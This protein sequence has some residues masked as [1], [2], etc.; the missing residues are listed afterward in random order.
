MLQKYR[1]YY[2]TDCRLDFVKFP[3][4]INIWVELSDSVGGGVNLK[5]YVYLIFLKNISLPTMRSVFEYHNR[6]FVYECKP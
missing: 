3:M 6:R 5:S 1:F 2:E 4:D